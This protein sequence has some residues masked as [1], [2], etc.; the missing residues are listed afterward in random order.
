MVVWGECNHSFHQEPVHRH[1]LYKLTSLSWPCF[2]LYLYNVTYPV[3]AIVHV[4]NGQV[5]FFSKVPEK[6]RHVYLVIQYR[7]DFNHKIDRFDL[8]MFHISMIES[9]SIFDLIKFY[10]CT[11]YF[12]RFFNK[13]YFSPA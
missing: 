7:A 4:Y 10:R 9:N 11:Y 1:L 12:I 8:R 3:Y 13:S 5:T 6:H 2:F